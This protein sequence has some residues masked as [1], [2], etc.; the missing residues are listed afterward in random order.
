MKKRMNPAAT[1]ILTAIIIGLLAIIEMS[2]SNKDPVTD[3]EFRNRANTIPECRPELVEER[4]NFVLTCI[5]KAKGETAS[6]KILIRACNLASK[7]V[8]CIAS[9]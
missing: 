1:K 5:D 7:D 2:C 6:P 4:A 3:Q 9:D 8:Y